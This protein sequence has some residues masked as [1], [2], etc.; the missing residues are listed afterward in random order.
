MCMRR[1]P[2]APRLLLLA[3]AF[4]PAR[5]ADP[6]RPLGK[7]SSMLRRVLPR[8]HSGRKTSSPR[9][10]RRACPH[11]G[12]PAVQH[13]RHGHELQRSPFMPPTTG[14][15]AMTSS[16]HDECVSDVKEPAL[17]RAHP[18]APAQ[19]GAAGRRAP[20]CSDALSVSRRHRRS[21][22]NSS[23][24]PPDGTA[25]GIRTR[26]P[27]FDPQ[28]PRH[29]EVR[30]GVDF[31]PAGECTYW[32]EN[33]LADRSTRSPR[34]RTSEK[35]ND[36]VCVWTNQYE[37]ARRLRH[38]VRAPQRDRSALP[39]HYLDLPHAGRALW[40]AGKLD[41]GYLKAAAD[42][43]KVVPVQ[44]RPR[45]P[46]DVV[47]GRRPATP[48]GTPSTA[49]PTPEVVP[50]RPTDGQVAPGR[51]GQPRPSSTPP[52]ARLGVERRVYLFTVDDSSRRTP[53]GVETPL[54]N[55]TKNTTP[56]PEQRRLAP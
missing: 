44:P 42:F 13:G 14:I 27:T 22:S 12:D 15:K 37:K 35:G 51:P 29:G 36:E 1:S 53:E 4:T 19:G 46:G 47:R 20:H 50:Q 54:F 49:S 48:S 10:P 41:D 17:H 7:S 3:T 18:K 56:E 11:R 33:S 23:A 34:R 24:S 16:S 9:E 55:G 52:T 39:K 26:S 2:D 8:L 40:A 43:P 25:R 45:T 31:N 38:D 21:G 5:A 6:P 30:P 28:A 32:I